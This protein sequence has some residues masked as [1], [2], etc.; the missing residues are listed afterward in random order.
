[1]IVS[2]DESLHA[3]KP[4]QIM[5][6]SSHS[7]VCCRAQAVYCFWNLMLREVTVML[8]CDA[9][10]KLGCCVHRIGVQTNMMGLSN[11]S[12]QPGMIPIGNQMHMNPHMGV[13]RNMHQM[14]MSGMM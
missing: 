9:S 7:H 11:P 8:S 13:P 4:G 5:I 6:N 2:S 1:M 12:M 14:N 10:L 3:Q